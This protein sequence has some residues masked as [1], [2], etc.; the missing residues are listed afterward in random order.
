MQVAEPCLKHEA[1]VHES[2]DFD[3]RKRIE[4]KSR[5]VDRNCD[6]AEMPFKFCEGTKIGYPCTAEI[7]RKKAGKLL[8]IFRNARGGGRMLPDKSLRRLVQKRHPEKPGGRR[9]LGPDRGD[10]ARSIVPPMNR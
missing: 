4:S 10:E 6:L 8:T 9:E 1:C 5:L 2:I 7:C 3:R